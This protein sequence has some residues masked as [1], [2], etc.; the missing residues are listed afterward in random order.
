MKTKIVNKGI[1]DAI[2]TAKL[3]L[4]RLLE[5]KEKNLNN[6]DFQK[7]YEIIESTISEDNSIEISL[8][9]TD[10]E[11]GRF[12]NFCVTQERIVNIADKNIFIEGVSVWKF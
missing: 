5:L 2:E 7:R 11:S 6:V 10:N 1:D 3:A 4:S 9:F 8:A 12:Y